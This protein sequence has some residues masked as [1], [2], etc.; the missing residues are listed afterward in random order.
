MIFTDPQWQELQQAFP[1]GVCDYTKPGVG[2]G[3]TM[4]WL[5]YQRPN[6]QVIYGGRELGSPP[7]SLAF[8]PASTN[9]RRT[10]PATGR[11][12]TG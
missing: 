12:F 1:T 11:Q 10:R 9:G 3:P 8:G 2:Q 5:T 6:G 7:G 4:T